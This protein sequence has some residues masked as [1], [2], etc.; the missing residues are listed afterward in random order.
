MLAYMSPIYNRS[1]EFMGTDDQG[2][3]GSPIVMD[4]ANFVQGM[5]HDKALEK[6]LGID[7]LKDGTAALKLFNNFISLPRRPDYDGFITINEGVKWAKTHPNALESPTPLNSLY[8]NTALLD[9]G[10]L[11]VKDFGI[12]NLGK[13]IPVNLFNNKNCMESILNEKLRATV[14]ALGR[15]NMILHNP[16]T[17]KVSVIND[18]ATVYDW[19][20]GDG[21]V[22]SSFINTERFRTALDDT[23]GFVVYY[24]G[25]G[26]LKK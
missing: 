22:R 12:R 25:F 13:K 23:H 21:I 1:G 2:L 15:V 19:N 26:T 3:Q 6:D 17:R 9:F 11:S 7:G 16:V 20:K 14:Y 10:S 18:A 5:A 8:V 24:Y 4:E